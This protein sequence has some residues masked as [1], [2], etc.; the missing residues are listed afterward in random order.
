MTFLYDPNNLRPWFLK[1]L[2]HKDRAKIEAAHHAVITRETAKACEVQWI[3][4]TGEVLHEGWVPKRA[5][6][7]KSG[8]M[9]SVEGEDPTMTELREW[10]WER[11]LPSDGTE[12]IQELENEMLWHGHWAK[13]PERL[14]RPPALRWV[15]VEHDEDAA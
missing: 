11:G 1:R 8:E 4:R 10:M 6:E 9:P 15:G 3:S 13:L 12:S 2:W 7:L 5:M 14:R